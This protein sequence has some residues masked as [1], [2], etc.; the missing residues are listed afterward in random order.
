[1]KL[2]PERLNVAYDR[3]KEPKRFII[4]MILIG[5]AFFLSSYPV[6]AQAAVMLWCAILMFCRS[7]HLCK[8]EFLPRKRS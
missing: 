1:M 2:Y 4:A 8:L 3:L 5:P 6:L 7:A